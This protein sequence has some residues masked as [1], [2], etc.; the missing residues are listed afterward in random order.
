MLKISQRAHE[1][2]CGPAD[3]AWG[4]PALLQGN[5]PKPGHGCQ[6]KVVR[7]PPGCSERGAASSASEQAARGAYTFISAVHVCR[8]GG[9]GVMLSVRHHTKWWIDLHRILGSVYMCARVGVCRH[10]HGAGSSGQWGLCSGMLC[11][12]HT[13]ARATQRPQSRIQPMYPLSTARHRGAG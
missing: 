12:Q 2:W 4:P 11:Q 5:Y 7:E 3:K 9:L 6:C 8:E 1:P 10:P 13:G